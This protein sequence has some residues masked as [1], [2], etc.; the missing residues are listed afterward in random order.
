MTKPIVILIILMFSLSI[1][2]QFD[3]LGKKLKKK[4]DNRIERKVDRTMDKGLDKTEN[5]F[6]DAVRGENN[7]ASDKN[8][9]NDN[10]SAGVNSTTGTNTNQTSDVAEKQD[11]TSFSYST[12]FDF[13]PG[14]NI[15]VLED[16][17]KEYV[18]DFPSSWN[19]NGTGEIVK[20]DNSQ[21]KW[22]KMH[23]RSTYIPDLPGTLPEE[24]TI[25]FDLATEGITKQTSSAA[26]LSIQLEDNNT[27]NRGKN[28]AEVRISP[29]QYT[30][31]E[32]R[33]YNFVDGKR[34]I[35][36]A[37][38][39]DIRQAM[40]NQPHVSIAVNK[41]RFRLWINEI[42]YVDIPRLL[43][44]NKIKHVKFYVSGF[45]EEKGETIFLKN[46]KIAEGGEDL[47]HKLAREGRIS[48]NGILFNVNSHIVKPG[49]YGIIRNVAQ[50][51]ENDPSM[52]LK[53]VGHTDD[54]GEDHHNLELSK[55][56][57]GS[58]KDIL[59][60]EFNIDNDRIV[61]DGKG[62]TEPVL[63][64]DSSVNKASNRRV[65][66]IVI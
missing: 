58:V 15:M 40:M 37:I 35:N 61:T 19:T 31:V 25:E 1:H 6:D 44:E 50:V 47:R 38:S 53:I 36:N 55:R 7:A 57:A 42:K 49:S 41:Q 56:R 51:M 9:S 66:F 30:P 28:Y 45:K 24:Y 11:N 39:A 54:D 2:A 20:I 48:T 8:T 10:K 60:R 18:G 46:L 13:V 5:A 16:F 62:E 52:K 65:E 64:N 3:N 12:K 21:E 34:I 22:F 26:I 32:I 17:S 29:C 63:P 43:P 27:F 4:V 59:T 33:V 23:S 14:D